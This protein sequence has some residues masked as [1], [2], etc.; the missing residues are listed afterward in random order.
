M[1]DNQAFRVAIIEDDATSS[2][3]LER[4][5]NA[6]GYAVDVARN[7]IEALRLFENRR[8][9]LILS[10]WKMPGMDGAELLRRVR[11]DAILSDVYFIML[12]SLHGSKY[13]V[14]ALEAGA[15]D[16]LTKPPNTSELLARLHTG[17]RI[18]QLQR[19]LKM[20]KEEAEAANRA[21]SDFLSN[22]SHEIR[23]PM[24]AI[25][26]MTE[27]TLD[28]DLA[29]DQRRFL[30]TV[31]VSADAL[32][33]LLNDIL[34]FSKIEAGKLEIESTEFNLRD[35]LDE[36]VRPLAVRAYEKGLELVCD[37][38]HTAPLHL[39]GDPNRLR[40]IVVN[41]VGNA[42]KFTERGEVAVRVE[43]DIPTQAAANEG[44]ICLRFAVRDTGIGV[45][46]GKQKLIFDAFSQAEQSTASKYGGTGLGLAISAQLSRMMGGRIWIESDLGRGSTFYFTSQFGLVHEPTTPVLPRRD[47]FHDTAVLVAARNATVLTFIEDRLRR[48]GMKVSTTDSGASAFDALKAAASSGIPYN[49]A[50]IDVS[51]QDIDGITV[52][53][54]IAETEEL[55]GLASIILLPISDKQGAERCARLGVHG[56]LMKPVTESGLFEAAIGILHAKTPE[57]SRNAV[58]RPAKTAVAKQTRDSLKAHVLLV[59]DNDLNRSMGKAQLDKLGC[60]SVIA[61]SGAEALKALG[62]E[63][64]DVVLLDIQMPDMNGF[65][66]AAAIRERERGAAKRTPVVAMTAHAMKGFREK[67]LESGMDGYVS[68]PVKLQN[69]AN[70]IESALQLKANQYKPAAET[71][72]STEDLPVLDWEDALEHFDGDAETVLQL[73]DA[74]F[75]AYPKHLAEL[76]TA[77]QNG[78]A[79]GVAETAHKDQRSLGLFWSRESP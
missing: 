31:Q 42:I 51:L 53:S 74:F 65:E 12:T 79:G 18:V 55:S 4:I 49:A 71:P 23:T 59:D 73:L 8:P 9:D 50:F 62:R 6:R 35:T 26:G 30:E 75:S 19:G 61:G 48:W 5:L 60:S 21:K 40:Q 76:R 32:L 45:P 68:K 58:E 52:A 3:I 17:Q 27:L 2:R 37:V 16:F 1:T 78:D 77:L 63:V 67:C 10:D 56:T 57:N 38:H 33:N 22:M 11:G 7:G 20:A 28:T 29:V 41:L 14:D 44:E 15:D 34:D 47:E 43:P 24:N 46:A 64:F 39:R 54:R 72:A 70:A 66:A 13:A 25:I 36:A 69:L